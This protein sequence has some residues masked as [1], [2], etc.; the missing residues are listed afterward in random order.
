MW[1][2]AAGSGAV[3]HSSGAP[4]TAAASLECRVMPAWEPVGR[5]L[6]GSNTKCCQLGSHKGVPQGAARHGCHRLRRAARQGAAISGDKVLPVPGAGCCRPKA[7]R[8]VRRAQRSRRDR[9]LQS[10]TKGDALAARR[11][12]GPVTGMPGAGRGSRSAGPSRSP[13]SG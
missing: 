7:Q 12:P 11:Q 1:K 5:E 3:W 4:G 10:P 13:E 6:R 2:D 8:A 9:A